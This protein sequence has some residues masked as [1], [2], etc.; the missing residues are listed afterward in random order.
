[1]AP[2]IVYWRQADLISPEALA[3]TVTIVGAGG[4]G[5]PVALALAKKGCRTLTRYDPDMVE[6]HNLPNQF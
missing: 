5:S 4:I 1:L 2:V 3:A 6:A